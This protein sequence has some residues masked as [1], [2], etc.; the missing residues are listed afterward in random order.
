M[1]DEV[2]GT[3]DDRVYFVTVESLARALDDVDFAAYWDEIPVIEGGVRVATEANLNG[4]RLAIAIL[5]AL[6]SA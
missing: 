4:R 5:A 3:V 2:H 6:D 1:A